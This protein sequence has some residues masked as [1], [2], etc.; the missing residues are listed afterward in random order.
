[1]Q[2][3]ETSRLQIAL[4]LPGHG[5]ASKLA[6]KSWPKRG[7]ESGYFET[8]LEF[9]K[10]DLK[11]IVEREAIESFSL[12]GYS[13]GARLALQLVCGGFASIDGLVVESSGAG[14][15]E[16]NK[17]NR[18]IFDKKLQED[19][20]TKDPNDLL[21]TW[22]DLPLFKGIKKH[23]HFQAMKE[24]L[25]KNNFLDVAKSLPYLSQSVMPGIWDRLSK[26]R[27]KTF[28]LYGELDEKYEVVC[29]K[30]QAHIKDSEIFPIKNASHNTHFMNAQAYAE[31]LSQFLKRISDEN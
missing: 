4:D 21:E 11:R 16:E 3:V 7:E 26:L 10:D 19:L 29:K 24:T 18:Q 2:K 30:L 25:L 28:I 6:A 20:L 14:I 22:Y 17:A 5:E 15:S 8:Y 12:V 9:L 1:M 23:P 13:M 31:R 27:V